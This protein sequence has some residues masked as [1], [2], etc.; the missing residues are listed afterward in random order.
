VAAWLTWD[1]R[2]RHVIVQASI[3]SASWVPAKTLSNRG[4]E[5]RDLSVAVGG[6]RTFVSWIESRNGAAALRVAEFRLGRWQR[7]RVPP[8]GSVAMGIEVAAAPDGTAAVAW[9]TQADARLVLHAVRISAGGQASAVHDLSSP[10]HS[11]EAFAVAANSGQLAVAWRESD[12]TNR[13]LVAETLQAGSLTWSEPAVLATGSGL[14]APVVSAGRS[15]AVIAWTTHR[16]AD[17]GLQATR[18]SRDVHGPQYTLLAPR[19]GQTITNPGVAVTPDGV[20]VAWCTNTSGRSA[21]GVAL[22]TA[23]N[24][25]RAGRPLASC[26][27]TAPHL[28]QIG[29]NTVLN[30]TRV[31]RLYLLTQRL[32]CTVLNPVHTGGAYHLVAGRLGVEAVS[33][34]GSA[35]STVVVRQL[36]RIRFDGRPCTGD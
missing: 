18:I 35:G 7:I 17:A 28:L 27:G 4:V 11:V 24:V 33:A 26:S 36:A 21:L 8:S 1:W 2:S 9:T 5:A 32:R 22:I 15:G 30:A 12:S 23:T 14:G 10:P 19:R 13:A 6:R 20:L 25:R 29:R 31:P 16:H 3:R 34:G